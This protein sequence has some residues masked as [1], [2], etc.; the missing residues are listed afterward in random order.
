MPLQIQI[1][2][3]YVLRGDVQLAHSSCTISD[4]PGKCDPPVVGFHALDGSSDD[5]GVAADGVAVAAVVVDGVDGVRPA[6]T[7]SRRQ[8]APLYFYVYFSTAVYLPIL[9]TCTLVFTSLV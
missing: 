2:L 4:R 9:S 5:D 6:G 3:L 1:H 7:S 8:S